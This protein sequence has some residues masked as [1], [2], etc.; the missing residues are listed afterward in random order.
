LGALRVDIESA[1]ARLDAEPSGGFGLAFLASLGTIVREGVEV[2]LLLT[3]LFALVA[4]S[5]RPDLVPAIR[6]GVAGAV[7]AELQKEHGASL[8]VGATLKNQPDEL[9]VMGRIDAYDPGSK[10]AR[11]LIIG[12]G[13]GDLKLDVTFLEGQNQTVLERFS[14]DGA[15]V[16]GGV[17]GASMGMEDMI[18]SASEKIVE[19]VNVFVPAAVSP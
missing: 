12:M 15:I 3:M 1:V 11:F 19:H 17:A 14:T 4:K 6:W 16:A 9:V 10:A 18:E 5:G 8:D 13:A 2:I 7:I